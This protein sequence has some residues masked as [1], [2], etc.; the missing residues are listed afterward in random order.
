M[1]VSLLP[2]PLHPPLQL[3]NH[4]AQ[5]LIQGQWAFELALLTSYL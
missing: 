4:L 2:F 3:G 5:L 1:L